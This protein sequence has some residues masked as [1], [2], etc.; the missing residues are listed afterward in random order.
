M[1]GWQFDLSLWKKND[2]EEASLASCVLSAFWYTPTQYLHSF[3]KSCDCGTAWCMSISL[4]YTSNEKKQH[5]YS[6]F[7]SIFQ[8]NY[9]KGF[10]S[11]CISLLPPIFVVCLHSGLRLVI[12]GANA[13]G[14]L[15]GVPSTFCSVKLMVV[16]NTH[17]FLSARFPLTTLLWK[18]HN[19]RGWMRLLWPIL[20]CT[21]APHTQ[22][23]YF[24]E[25]KQL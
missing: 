20:L 11:T 17:S 3:S 19:Y 2:S 25:N 18:L 15:A 10:C 14:G 16:D 7:E 23:Q 21:S 24:D 9:C 13:C 12:G 4:H 5:K 6:R 22:K 1:F 8:N